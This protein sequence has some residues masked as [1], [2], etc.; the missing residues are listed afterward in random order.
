[1][2]EFGLEL[3]LDEAA[4][5]R[6][7]HAEFLGSIRDWG[8]QTSNSLQKLSMFVLAV[9]D[10]EDDDIDGEAIKKFLPVLFADI[11][12]AFNDLYERMQNEAVKVL[13]SPFQLHEEHHPDCGTKDSKCGHQDHY[14]KE[15]NDNE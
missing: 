14:K 1:M 5:A 8:M 4:Q 2:E 6:I 12:E 3:S 11:V 13:G 10:T 9:M 15:G 7:A